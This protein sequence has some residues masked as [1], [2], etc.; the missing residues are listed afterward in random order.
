M[1]NIKDVVAFLLSVE[2]IRLKSYLDGGGVWTIGIGSTFYRDGRKVKQGDE[3]TRDEAFALAEFTANRFALQVA[4]VVHTKVT[5]DQ[6]IALVSVAFN[7][8]FPRFKNSLILK[9]VN[10]DPNDKK[11]IEALFPISFV[12]VDGQPNKGLRNRKQIELKKYFSL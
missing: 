3:I 6:F 12:T 1:Y 10:A 2:S 11:A 7:C 5:K 4:D 9:Q 8:G